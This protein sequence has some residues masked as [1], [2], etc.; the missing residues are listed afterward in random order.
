MVRNTLHAGSLVMLLDFIYSEAHS[1]YV[2][3]EFKVL[4]VETHVYM[5]FH[6]YKD[7][8]KHS[9]Y[10]KYPRAIYNIQQSPL[11]QFLVVGWTFLTA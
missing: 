8:K 5:S 1:S 6:P 3:R 11:V 4:A 7:S 2:K 10:S 9:F